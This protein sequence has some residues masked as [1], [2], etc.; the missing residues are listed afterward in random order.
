ML[1]SKLKKLPFRGFEYSKLLEIAKTDIDI[2][3]IIRTQLCDCKGEETL[4]LNIYGIADKDRSRIY[5]KFRMYFQKDDY[6]T[7]DYGTET[8]KS[9]KFLNVVNTDSE[10]ACYW[11]SY[12]SFK[13]FDESEEALAKN[14]ICRWLPNLDEKNTFCAIEKYQDDI[15]RRKLKI[16]H[17]KETDVID[18]EMA[19]FGA[20]PDDYQDFVKNKV[21]AQ[22]NY[23]FYNTAKKRAYCT[24]CKY[25]F[26][27]ENKRL[28]HAIIGIWN[29]TDEVGHNKGV[30]CPYCHEYLTC[31]S[32]GVSRRKLISVEWSVIAQKSG[33]DV[34]T[35]YFIHT[36]DFRTNFYEPKITT[37]EF[38][39]TVHQN[40]K[41]TDYM[42]AAFKNTNEIRWCYYKSKPGFYRPSTYDEPIGSV[43][44]YNKNFSKVVAGTCMEY[45]AIDLFFDH[46]Y[47]RYKGFRS[48]WIID[49]YFNTY[50]K[51]KFYEQ[52]LKIGFYRLA[53]E[54]MGDSY[55]L[56]HHFSKGRKRITE[57]LDIN[58]YQLG[59][60]KKIGNP[61]GK[62]LD[63]VKYKPDLTW[64]EYKELRRVD[65]GKYGR[66]YRYFIDYAKYSTIHKMVRY[67]E[68]QHIFVPKDYFD[69]ITWM[70]E[71]DYDLHSEFYLFPKDFKKAHDEAYK[72]YMN[73]QDAKEKESVERFNAF[74]KS[75]REKSPDEFSISKDGLMIRM[76]YQLN[77]LKTEGQALHHCV[78]SYTKRVKDGETMIFFIRKLSEPDKP[79]YTLEW[80]GHVVQCRGYKNCDMTDD[81][82]AFVKEFEK[83]MMEK[84]QGGKVG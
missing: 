72:R 78:A 15:I 2:K 17:K 62:D 19:K 67:V 60:L 69:Y 58:R 79:F 10:W 76:P 13:F 30:T 61:S 5:L 82:K 40:S 16:K 56:T 39:R 59:M 11:W 55:F 81:V 20:L 26:I 24:N 43:F 45:S 27:L 48:P 70:E 75:L 68:K 63:I 33:K 77:E 46:I 41:S 12:K 42:Y 21:F 74:L 7:F 36:K 35:R 50:R 29:N 71:M 80:K 23:I 54:G 8:W 18:A 52:I 28:R 14:V 84:E 9:G 25:S 65:D 1:K 51:N 34:L 49:N 73:F 83:K 37:R 38:Y 66:N 64:D 22:D 32:E 3:Y 44:I 31:K 4:V 53:A 57:T 47:G 6:I